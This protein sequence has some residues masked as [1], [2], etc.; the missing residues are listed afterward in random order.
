MCQIFRREYAALS[1]V[2]FIAIDRF[3]DAE[4]YSDIAT[5]SY[6]YEDSRKAGLMSKPVERIR[7]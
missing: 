2:I 3:P 5:D 1:P 4:E 6:R 7:N